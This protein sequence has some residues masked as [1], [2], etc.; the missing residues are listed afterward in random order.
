MR[1]EILWSRTRVA[2]RNP[3]C[4]ACQLGAEVDRPAPMT[5]PM[6][7]R[8]FSIAHALPKPQRVRDNSGVRN[9]WATGS[10]GVSESVIPDA[11]AVVAEW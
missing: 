8:L 9:G 11:L 10:I 7:A 3:F 6:I 4:L 1:F 2:R 5:A